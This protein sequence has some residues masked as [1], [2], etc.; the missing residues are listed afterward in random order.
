[1]G[2]GKNKGAQGGLGEQQGHLLR[3]Y[4]HAMAGRLHEPSEGKFCVCPGQGGSA[5]GHQGGLQG[6]SDL[7]VEGKAPGA[8][9]IWGRALQEWDKGSV[10]L[11]TKVSPHSVCCVCHLSLHCPC[12]V[13]SQGAP[14]SLGLT[15]VFQMGTISAGEVV[16]EPHSRSLTHAAV[17]VPTEGKG[18]WQKFTLGIGGGTTMS[19]PLP[20]QMPSFCG[21]ADPQRLPSLLGSSPT[22]PSVGGV[23]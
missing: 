12:K 14:L 9:T 7:R 4:L 8:R 5:P 16:R 19:L 17:L 3:H 23:S 21:S 15:P 13:A 1:M 20:R 10:I 18:E 6:R 11:G 2:Q 22:Y